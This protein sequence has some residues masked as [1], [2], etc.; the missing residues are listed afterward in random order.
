MELLLS[1]LQA[2]VRLP[3]SLSCARCLTYSLSCRGSRLASRRVIVGAH[4]LTM[5]RTGSRRRSAARW[6]VERRCPAGPCR[7]LTTTPGGPLIAIESTFAT[8]CLRTKVASGPGHPPLDWPWPSSSS[9]LREPAGEPS[10]H[11][12]RSHSS[13]P[14]PSSTMHTPRAIH[15]RDTDQ[16]PNQPH[17]RRIGSYL[18]N[19]W[20]TGHDN[21]CRSG[22]P[23]QRRGVL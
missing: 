11:P 12:T 14:A 3:R 5:R 7:T 1:D 23:V 13:E 8:R 15:R 2:S 9:R 10:T 17:Q 18:T 21:S 22:S 4:R 20:S 16:T 6:A 19:A